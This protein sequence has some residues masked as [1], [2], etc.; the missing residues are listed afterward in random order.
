MTA[1][2]GFA[3]FL[4][5]TVVCLALVVLTGMKHKRKPHYILVGC[6]VALLGITV[7]YAEKLG[8]DY[9]L[10]TAGMITPIHLALAKFTVVAYLLPVISGFMTIRDARHKKVHFKIAMFILFMTGI[11]FATG[12]MMVMASE[13]IVP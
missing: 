10:S 2:Q 9:D 5:L 8:H 13:P 11:T 7:Y 12:L 1:F 6:A 3:A 4:V